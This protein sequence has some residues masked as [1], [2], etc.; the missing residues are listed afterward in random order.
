M[1]LRG[2][3]R[4]VITVAAVAMLMVATT[5]MP[6]RAV[7]YDVYILTGQSNALGTT[8]AGDSQPAPGVHEADGQTA[9]W[10]SNVTSTNKAYPPAIHGDS[11]GRLTTLQPQQGDG[12]ANPTFWGPEFG[13][14]RRLFEHGRR[15]TLVIKACRGGGSNVFW[16]KAAFEAAADSGHMWGHLRDTVTGALAAVTATPGDSFQIRGFLYLQGES[17]TAADAA[18]AERRLAELVANLTAHVE[19]AHPGT[20]AGMAVVIGEIAASRATAA[21]IATTRAQRKLAEA[22]AAATFVPTADLPLKRD[23]I[24]FGG[25]AKLEIGR[26]MAEALLD[27]AAR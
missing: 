19:A 5:A 15:R 18:A 13:F 7:E 23:G 20:T 8:A 25:A 14:A 2:C 3:L 17:N 4:G 9:F 16:D 10:W 6:A 26:R 21:R 12:G 22:S 24:H 27:D 11:G 1:P